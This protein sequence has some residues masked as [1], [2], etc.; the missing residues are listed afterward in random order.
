MPNLLRYP[1]GKSRGPLNK[2]IVE[3][4]RKRYTGGMFG[5]LFFGGGGIT[6][7]LIKASI[8]DNVTICELDPSLCNLWEAV[9]YKPDPLVRGLIRIRPSVT[10]FEKSKDRVRKGRGNAI[11]YLIVNRMSH[12][13]RGVMAGPQGGYEQKG[14]YKI[15]CRWNVNA[16]EKTIYELHELFSNVD[17]D[18]VCGSFADCPR[19]SFLYMDPP[20]YEVGSGLYQY[21]F[22]EEDHLELRDYLI[23]QPNWLLSYNNHPAVREFY[24]DFTIKTASTAGNGGNKPN[25]ELLIYP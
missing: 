7:S 23:K 12:G 18:L 19:H 17:T 22:T 25:S 13:G 5:E 11:D 16:L 10:V 6:I 8:I 4:I 3:H 24:K 9:L 21:S 1:G 20:Y 2:E 15:N 14:K